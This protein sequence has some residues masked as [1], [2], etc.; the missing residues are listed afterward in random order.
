MDSNTP[1]LQKIS[2]TLPQI[3]KLEAIVLRP[4]PRVDATFATSALAIK[5]L[6]LHAD[7]RGIDLLQKLTSEQQVLTLANFELPTLL[8]NQHV[9]LPSNRQI[10]LIQAEHIA[11][12][13]Q[14]M[15]L[16]NL[17]ATTIRR[18][19]VVSNINLLAIKPLFKHQQHYLQIGDVLLEITGACTPCSRM[20]TLLGAG[21]YNA[22]R[23]HGGVNAKIIR[24]GLLTVGD[25][26]VLVAQNGAG[27][28]QAALDF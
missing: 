26:A 22:M 28:K 11:L 4:A 8:A 12:L 16:P 7:R 14:W 1:S 25:A 13:A 27:D 24:G 18:N 10:T 5:G 21:G 23:G 15:Q 2:Q 19:L 20:E 3:G 9:R 17:L 6:G